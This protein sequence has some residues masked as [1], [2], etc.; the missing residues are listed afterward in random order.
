MIRSKFNI[1]ELDARYNHYQ[2]FKYIIEMSGIAP[3][4]VRA[5]EFW[6]LV[7]W[8]QSTYGY[9]AEIRSWGAIT[10]FETRARKVSGLWRKTQL[11]KLDPPLECTD[12]CSPHWSYS[13]GRAG[14]EFRIYVATDQELAFFRLSQKVDQ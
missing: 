14:D 4:E 13:I 6:R 8:F 5:L 1:V 12:V 9:S 11:G 7:Q 2:D 10:R 3:R